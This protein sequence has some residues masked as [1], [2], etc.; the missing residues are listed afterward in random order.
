MFR[1]FFHSIAYYFFL[2]IALSH[3]NVVIIVNL[4]HPSE[5]CTI[6]AVRN[7]LLLQHKQSPTLLSYCETALFRM[8][9]TMIQSEVHFK[10]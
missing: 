9:K 8:L 1:Q 5:F 4:F 2:A 7:S 6:I 10:Y 3:C